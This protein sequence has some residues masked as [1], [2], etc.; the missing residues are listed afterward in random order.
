[1]KS[2]VVIVLTMLLVV[3][4]SNNDSSFDSSGSK[5][6]YKPSGVLASVGRM[7]IDIPLGFV[8]ALKDAAEAIEDVAVTFVRGIFG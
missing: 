5:D 2:R 8:E 4:Y 7:F 1:M 6:Y 3:C